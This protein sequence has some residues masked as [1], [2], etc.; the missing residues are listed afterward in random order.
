MR[1]NL[2]RYEVMK[3]GLQDH[4]IE[5]TINQKPYFMKMRKLTEIVEQKSKEE[6]DFIIQTISHINF[7]NIDILEFVGFLAKSHVMELTTTRRGKYES[8]NNH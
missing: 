6:K 1:F 5:F 8:I 3:R 4:V 2:F 7:F